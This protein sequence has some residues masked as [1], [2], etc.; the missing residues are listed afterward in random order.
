M[1]VD[2]ISRKNQGDGDVD[3]VGRPDQLPG[4]LELFEL[5]FGWAGAAVSL[6]GFGS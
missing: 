1:V 4:A 3:G 2:D 5:V 6:L